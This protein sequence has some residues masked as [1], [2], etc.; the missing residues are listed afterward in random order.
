[1]VAEAMADIDA[2]ITDFAA[3]RVPEASGREQPQA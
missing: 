3:S 1:M 2:A